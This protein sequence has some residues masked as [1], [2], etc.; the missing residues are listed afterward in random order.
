[1]DDIN[2]DN[3]LDGYKKPNE[4]I[5][6]NWLKQFPLLHRYHR[7]MMWLAIVMIILGTVG[8]GRAALLS[9]SSVLFFGILLIIGGILQIF[10]A[11]HSK[12]EMLWS[13]LASLL[14]LIAGG[15]I[16]YDPL[17]STIALTAIIAGFILIIGISRCLLALKVRPLPGW[18]ALMLSGIFSVAL[19]VMLFASWPASGLW[20]IGLVIALELLFDGFGLLFISLSLKDI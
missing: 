13:G 20:F 9:V 6:N 7:W 8:L 4:Q 1:M 14:Y 2:N 5:Q 3:Q 10:H 12:N 11:Y 17:G 18:I 16:L 19:A 15:V